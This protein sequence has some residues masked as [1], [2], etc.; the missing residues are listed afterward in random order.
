VKIGRPRSVSGG[1]VTPLNLDTEARERLARIA[2]R[3]DVSQSEVARQALNTFEKDGRDRLFAKVKLLTDQIQS[4]NRVAME[5]VEEFQHNIHEKQ[6]RIDEIVGDVQQEL[7]PQDAAPDDVLLLA[8]PSHHALPP[9][10]SKEAAFGYL[11]RNPVQV[12]ERVGI[13]RARGDNPGP[14]PAWMTT[15]LVEIGSLDAIE[16]RARQ[17]VKAVPG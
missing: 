4:I 7:V 17:L 9:K 11:E 2:K 1:K 6:R 16:T 8:S 12:I 14:Q 3:L 10:A 5:L 15:L 13:V